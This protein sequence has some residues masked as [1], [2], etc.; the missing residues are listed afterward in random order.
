M[1]P[2]LASTP[3]TAAEIAALVP[4]AETIL[5][6][7]VIFN[8]KVHLFALTK[9]NA[10]APA[11]LQ[12]IPLEISATKLTEL[13]QTFRREV[14][15]RKISFAASAQ[16]LY[17]H[18]LKPAAGLL[19]QKKNVVIVPDGVLWELPF[20]A[21]MPAEKHYFWQD[22]TIFY[23]P[24]LTA[25]REIT[26]RHADRKPTNAAMTLLALGNPT[27]TPNAQSEPAPAALT[28]AER[29][30]QQLRQVYGLNASKV[31]TGA[32]ATETAFK[33]EASKYSVLHLATHGIYD[34]LNPMSSRVLLA[35]SA[36]EDGKVEAQEII[37]LKLTNE[38]IVLSACE[39][40]RGHIGP[41]EG[42]IGLT[43]AFLIAGCPTLVASQWE[44]RDDST[45]RLMINFHRALKNTQ[46][47]RAEALRQA[48]LSL[49]KSP[50][51]NH[52]YYWAGFVLIGDGY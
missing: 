35:A 17:Q 38:L 22:H 47:P 49:L 5:L 37:N 1:S 6:E 18:L 15:E 3:L 43:W 9:A 4:T 33:A 26:K 50:D 51:Y 21:L 31:L 19:S 11:E 30:V 34:N 48:A 40:G 8:E 23:A 25:L 39:T 12:T 10:Q 32:A 45:S 13:V 41:G 46:Q 24:S 36:S 14:A 42:V 20:Q 52:P 2:L 16:A 7:F 44:V 28:Y 29:Q 27:L